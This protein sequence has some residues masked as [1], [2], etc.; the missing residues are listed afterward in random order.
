MVALRNASNACRA[1]AEAVMHAPAPER[2]I[3]GGLLTEAMVALGFGDVSV[4]GLGRM[5]NLLKVH[6]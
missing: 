2:L 5:D 3:K 4:H 6:I 1:C